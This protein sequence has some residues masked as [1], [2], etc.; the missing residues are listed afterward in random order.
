[1]D[2]SLWMESRDTPKERPG[3]FKSEAHV[4]DIHGVNE[5]SVA[6]EIINHLSATDLLLFS[7]MI[8]DI[9]EN[10]TTR[11]MYDKDVRRLDELAEWLYV[12]R[13]ER[14]QDGEHGGTTVSM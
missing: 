5:D 11:H 3:T 10:P 4:P 9:L 14:S 8:K 2:G 7:R 13:K 12:T 6:T 1:M